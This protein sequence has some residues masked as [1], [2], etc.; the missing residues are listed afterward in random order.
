MEE[1]DADIQHWMED[2][3]KTSRMLERF[4]NFQVYDFKEFPPKAYETYPKNVRINI[5]M[6]YGLVKQYKER[7]AYFGVPYQRL[8][9]EALAYGL[10][11]A[12][13]DGNSPLKKMDFSGIE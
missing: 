9:R 5:R 3:E 6:P 4:I 8:M 13:R 2:Y 7:A 10:R 1:F 12:Q 11:P